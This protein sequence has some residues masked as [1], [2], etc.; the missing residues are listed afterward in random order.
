M[1]RPLNKS[2][3]SNNQKF[4]E[5]SQSLSALK[6]STEYIIFLNKKTLGNLLVLSEQTSYLEN[7]ELPLR[8]QTTY[9]FSNQVILVYE[10]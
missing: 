10:S 2:N 9:K 7:L 4:Q 5:W 8:Y 6:S 3:F 1:S